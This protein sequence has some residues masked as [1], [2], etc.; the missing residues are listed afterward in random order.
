MGRRVA[1]ALAVASVICGVA[2]GPAAASTASSRPATA[3][4]LKAAQPAA[5]PNEARLAELKAVVEKLKV[6]DFKAVYAL[7]KPIAERPDLD[8]QSSESRHFVWY[9]LGLSALQTD[10]PE[11]A[12]KALV[13]ATALDGVTGWDWLLRAI[14][15]YALKDNDD[16]VYAFATM[17]ETYPLQL[18]ELDDSF[19]DEMSRAALKLP[20]GEQRQMSLMDALLDA[21]WS[22][23]KPEADWSRPWAEHAA[24][25]LDRGDVARAGKAAA[26]VV[27]PGTVAAMRADNRF[28][29]LVAKEPARFDVTKA[30]AARLEAARASAARAPKSLAALDNVAQ[31]LNAMGRYEE[32][33][34]LTREAL[35]K[36]ASAWDDADNLNWTLDLQA[37]ALRDLGRVDEALA[38]WRRAAGLNEQGRV[39]V[40]QTLNLADMLVGAGRPREA[41]ATLETVKDGMSGYGR[42]VRANIRACALAELDDRAEAGEAVAEMAASPD[43]E[44][45]PMLLLAARICLGDLDAAAAGLIVLLK[46]PETRLQALGEVQDAPPPPGATAYL[47]GLD[48][49]LKA[50]LARP[51]VRAALAPVGR[52]ERQPYPAGY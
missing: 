50:L 1:I 4:K 52:I 34:V 28:A 49:R 6:Q 32:T 27:Q 7:V 37:R 17:A 41:L 2:A 10:K 40:S 23:K 43:A 22:P 14:A 35:A 9:A 5:P 33:L 11:E 18:S 12:H 13:K 26:R 39:N 44:D 48:A 15:A 30:H 42:M 45:A 51:D 31:A 21:G 3:D 20:R 36:P 46:D 24:R 29:P 16:A 8:D 47:R 38:V 25:L 19:F